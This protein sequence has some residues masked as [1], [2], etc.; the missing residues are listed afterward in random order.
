MS[1]VSDSYLLT[2]TSTF[3]YM[4]KSHRLWR[5]MPR[6]CITSFSYCLGMQPIYWTMNVY[7][8]DLSMHDSAEGYVLLGF[9]SVN[10]VH[11]KSSKSCSIHVSMSVFLSC[12][13]HLTVCMCACSPNYMYRYVVRHCKC[14]MKKCDIL[15]FLPN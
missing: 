1:W 12:S 3:L 6:S 14:D 11:Y 7:S 10:N 9:R 8:I 13:L 15:I 4:C 2:C 5:L